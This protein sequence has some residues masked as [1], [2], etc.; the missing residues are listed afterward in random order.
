MKIT[1][2]FLRRLERLTIVAKKL[3]GDAPQGQHPS[4]RRG[5]SVEFRDHRR[6]VPGDEL[7]YVDWN[8]YARFGVPFVK[9]FAAEEAVHVGVVVDASES[10]SF[11]GKFEAARTIAAALSYI[12]L[13]NLDSLTL[14][15]MGEKLETVRASLRGRHPVMELLEAIDGLTPGGRTDFR[16][17]F[18]DPLVRLRGRSILFIVTDFYDREGYP[19]AIRSLRAQKF[20]VNLIHVVAPDEIE[21]KLDGRYVRVDLESGARRKFEVTPEL[22]TRYREAWWKFASGVDR[23]ALEHEIACVRLKSD[24]PLEEMVGEILKTSGMLAKRK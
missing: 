2:D 3:F 5:P 15:R 4:L 14:Y 13:V 23:F 19:D 8:V 10:M 21:P 9:E 11:G 7:R 12:S 16:A 17:S 18:R 22:L 6:Y 1:E 24:S 20:D